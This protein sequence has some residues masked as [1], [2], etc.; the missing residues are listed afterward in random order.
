MKEA[1]IMGHTNLTIEN[2]DEI[3][4]SNRIEWYYE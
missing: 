3:P 2:F 4:F 1:A